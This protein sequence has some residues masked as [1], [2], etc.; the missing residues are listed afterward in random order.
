[1]NNLLN[2]ISRKL[3]AFSLMWRKGVLPN[4]V[5]PLKS[6]IVGPVKVSIGRHSYANGLSVYGWQEG[7][8]VDVGAFCSIAEGVT[9]LA[10][11]EHN[12]R[13]VSTSSHI[14]K[15]S[16]TGYVNSKGNVVIGNDV[17]IGHGVTVLSGV[18]VG[19]GAVL[20]A[21]AVVVRDVP[22]YAIVGGV[23]AKVIKY[24]FSENVI[25]KL[26][27]IRWWEWPDE[28]IE[29]RAKCFADINKFVTSFHS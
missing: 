16:S 24:R 17:W 23:P 7:L 27:K 5:N 9:I 21:G 28:L 12:Y 15:I 2:K 1:M 11:G 6:E 29:D 14:Q 25:E 8:R 4:G 3:Y 20:A 22:P 26:I 18:T 13:V 10:G 19:D